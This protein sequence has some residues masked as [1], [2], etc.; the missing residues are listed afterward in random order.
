MELCMMTAS[1]DEQLLP[2]LRKVKKE[3]GG[4]LKVK[5]RM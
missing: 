3:H 5:I 1:K 2:L 4:R